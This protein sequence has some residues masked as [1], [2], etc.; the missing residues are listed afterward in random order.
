[1]HQHESQRNPK[2]Q[3]T[4]QPLT[5]GTHLSV[6]RFRGKLISETKVR[7]LMQKCEYQSM[8]QILKQIQ[9]TQ[10]FAA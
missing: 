8:A 5:S 1:M 4:S 6:T 3:N 7:I 2:A 9:R 10:S